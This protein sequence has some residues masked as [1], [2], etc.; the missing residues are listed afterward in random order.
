MSE[1]KAI[2]WDLETDLIRPRNPCPDIVCG[3]EGTSKSSRILLKD[4][5]IESF[6]EIL[7]T[8][9][10][11]LVGTYLVYDFSCIAAQE[12]MLR[13]IDE[14]YEQGRIWDISTAQ[15]IIDLYEGT[16]GTVDP[17]TGYS[18]AGIAKRVLGVVPAGKISLTDK[19]NFEELQKKGKGTNDQWRLRFH[20]LRN[21]PVEQWPDSA[22]AYCLE[23]VAWP[24]EIYR[25]QV[26]Y[27]EK[28][29]QLEKERIHRGLLAWYLRL[30]GIWGIAVNPHFAKP[31][32]EESRKAHEEFQKFMLEKGLARREKKGIVRNTKRIKALV[33]QAYGGTLCGLCNGKWKA[34]AKQPVCPECQGEMPV[35]LPETVPETS[36][37]D[38]STDESA[39][40]G[41]G[42]PILEELL[43]KGDHEKLWSTYVP[44]LQNGIDY[45]FISP[46]W[47]ELVITG[48]TSCRAPNL[49]NQS[50]TGGVREC[51]VPRPGRL[52]CSNDYGT[53]ELFTLGQLIV[54]LFGH[55]ELLDL[56]NSGIDVHLYT[57]SRIIGRDFE[58]MSA[59]KKKGDKSIKG[60]RALGKALNFALSGGLGDVAFVAHARDVYRV[61]LCHL[62]GD[63]DRCGKEKHTNKYTK[64]TVCAHCF[65]IGKGLRAGWFN[66]LPEIREYHEWVKT[67]I[68]AGF[69]L[70]VPG[71]KEMGAGLIRGAC[72]FTDGANLGFQGIAARLATSAYI[73]ASR[74]MYL[75]PKSILY[76]SRI[77]AF[78]HDEILSEH[79]VKIASKCA[80]RVAEI[81]VSEGKR[82]MPDA[83]ALAVE[84]S[85][86]VRWTKEAESEYGVDEKGD[87]I[88]LPIGYCPQCK[89][90][91]P[92]DSNWNML[93]GQKSHNGACSYTGRMLEADYNWV[94]GERR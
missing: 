24:L 90:W 23:D 50:R 19:D 93:R 11:R 45:G 38:V 15:K 36:G 30:S 18:L 34:K 59:L 14:A 65:E 49:Q 2:A 33:A 32:I 67:Q 78:I 25:Y 66:L 58:E 60:W 82:Y 39:L 57:T 61:K 6:G 10:A 48:R 86:M 63:A 27:F 1:I 12:A 71:S 26:Y 74:E 83:H 13:K 40:R 4:E 37:G 76:G 64:E 85:L 73:Q 47:N 5:A 20:L 42:D 46:R 75:N 35:D 80:F 89:Q 72:G 8:S 68:A 87:K 31:L 44:I 88:V 28:I 21:I 81:M 17:R 53:L 16:Q 79:P 41:S 84:P 51:F 70:E 54:W 55:S 92:V 43:K 62:F 7:Y 91:G 22:R 56:L 94:T 52:L 29:P 9:S 69:C 77:P 3:I